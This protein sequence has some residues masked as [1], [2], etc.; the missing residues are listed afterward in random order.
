MF[1]LFSTG[2]RHTRWNCDWS[3]DVCSSDLTDSG[4]RVRVGGGSGFFVTTDGMILTNKHVVIEKDAEYTAVTG[5]GKEHSAKVLTRDPINDVAVLKVEVG[6]V[7]HLALGDSSTIELGQTAI[8]I[9][10]ALG[11]FSNTVSKGIISGLGRKVS[12]AFGEGS[13]TEHLR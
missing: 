12:A 2:R 4:T 13:V 1:F 11:M 7:P 5:D 3:S 10:N 8:A 9:G 6:S